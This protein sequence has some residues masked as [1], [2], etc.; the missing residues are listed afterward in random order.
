[1]PEVILT[2]Q[3]PESLLDLGNILFDKSAIGRRRSS[4]ALKL[5]SLANCLYCPDKDRDL[6]LM[7]LL[8]WALQ[9]ETIRSLDLPRT[10]RLE[11]ATLSFDLQLRYFRLSF[12]PRSEE[13]TQR[14]DKRRA[15]SFTFAED[16]VW[17]RILNFALTLI[18]FILT[19]PSDWQFSRPGTENL[20]NFGDLVRQNTSVD[21][22][23]RTTY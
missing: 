5:L 13:I 12:L 15:V 21:D 11:K 18:H 19:A 1:L 22:R 10:E 23:S 4:L 6:A 3:G 20:E 16:S 2:C 14:F 17:P 7:Y 8:L 9:E